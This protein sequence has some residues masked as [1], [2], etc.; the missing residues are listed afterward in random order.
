M[1]TKA[2][3]MVIGLVLTASIVLRAQD[4]PI[5]EQIKTIRVFPVPIEWAGSQLPDQ[6]Q[7]ATLLAAIQSCASRGVGGGF[8]DLEK[9]LSENPQ[10]GWGS[11]LHVNLAEYYR[12]HGSYSLALRHWEMAWNLSK[13]EPDAASQRLAMRALAGWTR[14]LASLGEKE[15]LNKLFQEADELHLPLGVYATTINGTKEGLAVMNARPG[16]SYRCGSFALGRMALGL[17]LDRT[18]IQKLYAVDSPD[19]GF[20]LDDLINLAATNK[21]EVEAVRWPAGAEPVVPSV[22]HWKLN[23]YAAITAKKGDLYRV[24]DPTFERHIWMDAATIKAEASGEFILPKGQVPPGWQ[25][26]TLAEC[27]NI[28]GKGYPSYMDDDGDSGP[29][30]GGCGDDDSEESSCDPP[31]ANDGASGGGGMPQPPPCPGCGMPQWSV[32]EPYIS[33]WLKDTPLLY[34]QSSGRW[35]RLTLSYKS[36]GDAQDSTMSGFGDKW[37]CNWQGVLQSTADNPDAMIN[38]R[39]GGGQ[40][41][42]QTDG[43]RSYKTARSFAMATENGVDPPAITMPSGAYNFYGYAVGDLTGN[44]NY[45]LTRRRDQ[46]GRILQEFNYQTV[47]NLARVV[48]V[49]DMDGRTNTLTYGNSS[50][51]NLITAVTD[52]YGRVAHFNYNA[53]G[54]LTNIVDVQGMST[55]F[56]YDGD[57]NIT[58]MV[59]PYGTTSFQYSSVRNVDDYGGALTRSLLITEANGE[60]QLYVYQ[61]HPMTDFGD[62][63]SYHWN[64]AQYQTINAEGKTNAFLLT[65]DDCNNASIKHWLHSSLI[66]SEYSYTVSDTLGQS[67]GPVVNGT[68][69]N[70]IVYNYQGQSGEYIADDGSG[71]LKRITAISQ[72]W[73][74]TYVTIARNDLGRPT[75]YTYYNNDSSSATYSNFFDASG[76]I[77]QYE[78]GPRGE[79]TRGYGYHPVI[80][81][82]LT[83]VTNAVGDVIRY[84]HDPD[85]LKVTSITF[86]GGMLRTNIYYASGS[87]QGFLAQQIDVGF[88]TNSFAYTNG[89]LWVQTNELGLVTTYAY[90]NLNRLVSTAFPDGTTISNI[91]DKLDMVAVKDRLNQWTRY[92]YNAV[93]QLM[94]ATNA[95]GQITTYDYCGCGA[96]DQIVRWNGATPVVTTFYYNIAGQPTNVVYPDG[97]QLNYV[98]DSYSRV[99]YVIDGVGHRLQLLYYMH[100]FENEVQSAYWG[101]G[102]LLYQQFDEYGRVTFTQDRDW[103]VTTNAYD[104][105]DRLVVRQS[106]GNRNNYSSGLESFAYDDRGLASYTDQLGQPTVFVRDAVGRILYETNANNEV[107]QFTYNPADELLSLTD[108]KNQITR[109]NYDT[110][111]RV[112]NKVDAT[113]AEIFRYQYDPNDRLTNRWSAAK[114]NTVYKYDFLGNL[115]NVVYAHATNYFRYDALNRLTNMVDAIGSTAFNWTAGDQL[116]GENGPWADDAVNYAYDSSRQRSRLTVAQPNASPWVQNYA[117]DEA[118]RLTNV[119]SPAGVFGYYYYVSY[120][121]NYGASTKISALYFS[122]MSYSY[123]DY[124]RDD[125]A[126]LTQL[127]LDTGTYDQLQYRYDAGS[128]VTQQVFTAANYINY[129]YDNIG[130]L[131]TAQG[132]DHY[133]DDGVG[134]YVDPPRRHEQFGY[135][136]D[137]AWNLQ[138]RTNNALVQNFN[139]NSLNELTNGTRSGTYTV[140][141]NASEWRYQGYDPGVTEVTVGGTGLSSGDAE[142]YYDGSW[143]RTNATLANGQNSYTALATDNLGRTASDSV[144][145][146]LAATNTF[147]YDLNG[148]LRTNNTRI[149]EYDDE[150]QLTRVTEPGL[151]KTEYAYD[152]LLRRRITRQYNWTSGSWLLASEIRYVYD[153]NLVVQERDG[154]N[155]PQV[156]YTRGNDLSSTLQGA[157]GI[158]GLLARTENGKL[159]AGDGFATAYYFNDANGN[160]KD[161][162]YTNG[163]LAAHYEYD[164][165]GKLQYLNGPVAEANTY[166]FSSKEWDDHAQIYYYGY[167]FYEPDLQR[168]VNQDPLGEEGGINLYEFNGN[169]PVNL[170]DLFGNCPNNLINVA[171]NTYDR[172]EKLQQG[173]DAFGPS[174]V[175]NGPSDLWQQNQAAQARYTGATDFN[176]A[177]SLSWDSGDRHALL[178]S[179]ANRADATSSLLYGA[180]DPLLAPA[181]KALSIGQKANDLYNKSI[182][183]FNETKPLNPIPHYDLG[184]YSGLNTQVNV[185][186]GYIPIPDTRANFQNNKNPNVIINRP[187]FKNGECFA[188]PDNYH[189]Y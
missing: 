162:V 140:A 54:L 62:M 92:G 107:L 151:W 66:G 178:S 120:P 45:F 105:L 109:W 98:Y 97:Y 106:F 90:D 50:F 58:N 119:V 19:G 169:N 14:L 46:Y 47:G 39:A 166:R 134:N 126:R 188:T 77:L 153:G 91:Y 76:T 69:Q 135:A 115:T 23:H 15:Q 73:G 116:A 139:V 114:G 150:N 40:E 88:R 30:D 123:I 83:S 75:V 22:V 181:Q 21:I 26:L 27:A 80:T 137:K 57:E 2:I 93:Q 173:V 163:L 67:A 185:V 108:G 11:S 42:F 113:M 64:R 143:A 99:Q 1:K 82:L 160:V 187:L 33:L 10:S 37:S 43:T 12:S 146:N 171:N 176:F 87:N 53:Q 118:L 174:G 103:L 68:R 65:S 152:G 141:G 95:N 28:Y 180:G 101:N 36:R 170:I 79:L 78:T 130:Q 70:H 44:T 60:H 55:Y 16:V 34:R 35:M 165:Y 158:G 132:F 129:T 59:S 9:F 110:Y 18:I 4:A 8:A 167:R 144:S 155:V 183:L 177:G 89:N 25:K 96:P 133:Y 149:Y 127:S 147:V 189:L 157:G 71:G 161:L 74:Y 136:Y 186:K 179:F 125:M 13:R 164:P 49:L 51:S 168:W 72:P 172:A 56:Q 156:T 86:P 100:G 148:N 112:T 121:N 94:A 81:N 63:A 184:Q 48:N 3:Q 117:Y 159:I 61:D 131:K 31:S 7:S 85:S 122:S 154:N 102:Q 182:G 29:P 24:E 41:T 128:Q 138:Y 32:S 104:F 111:G 20:H 17:G 142:L 6:Q 175:W 52:A 84:T 38:H 5:V 145:V 124:E